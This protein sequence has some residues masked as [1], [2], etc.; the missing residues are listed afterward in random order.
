[1]DLLAAWLLFPL[2]LAVVAL[3]CGLLVDRLSDRALPGALLLPVGAATVLVLAR[4]LVAVPV[5]GAAGLA[6][7]LAVALGGLVVGLARLRELRPDPAAAAAALGVFAVFGAPVFLSGEP[8]LAGSFVLPDTSHQL[9]LAVHLGDTGTDW[10]SLPASSF[11]TGVGKYLVTAY[12]IGPQA[13]LGLLAPLGAIDLAWLYQPFLSFLAAITALSLY[14]LVA[15]WLASRALAAV[16]AFVGAQPA[17]VLGFALQGSIKEITG[18]AMIVLTSALVAVA[19]AER[20]PSQALLPAA[21]AAGAALGALGPVAVAYVGLPAAVLGLVWLERWLRRPR[22]RALA[23]AVA[24]VAVV[25]LLV[26]P[27]LSGASQAYSTGRAVLARGTAELGNL[28][29][30]L[31]AAQAVGPWL[32]GDYR[33]PVR[34]EALNGVLVAV[35]LVAALLGLALAL[36]RR[37]V[38]PLLLVVAV[39]PVSVY[40]LRRG[41]PYADAKVLV[42]AAPAVLTTAVFGAAA[43]TRGRWRALGWGLAA[44]VGAGV[45]VSNALAY[46]EVR[47]APYQR[48]RELARINE[49]F[50][51]QGPAVFT[52]YDEYAKY[53]LRDVR[54]ISQP[55]RFL[56]RFPY[57][58]S[59]KAM[60]D[61]DPNGPLLQRVPLVVMRRS[62]TVSRPPSNFRRVW[63][64]R[65]YEVWRRAPGGSARVLRHLALGQSVFQPSARPRCAQVASM[66]R[67]AARQGGRLAYVERPST[68]LY[69][70]LADSRTN[71]QFGFPLRVPYPVYPKAV[72]IA[73]AGRAAAKVR[74]PR[75]GRYRPYLEGSFGRGYEV[76]LDG[77]RVGKAAYDPSNPGGSVRLSEVTLSAGVHSLELVRG[78]GT[79]RPGNGGGYTSN[80]LY[81]GALVLSPPL[82]EAPPVRYVSPRRAAGLCRRTLD[83]VEVVVPAAS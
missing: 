44:V 6:V 60:I 70:P 21:L 35:A 64:G 62:P 80:L 58:P 69:D 57:H 25:A 39:V 8:S 27:V 7:L 15:R 18:I 54:P 55:E 9:A 82:N 41:T 3:G 12:P 11:R 17:L 10:R 47:A 29:G 72:V 65:S 74:V 71:D 16:V 19:V 20:R 63:S 43:L 13:A 22:S 61:L 48:Y 49:R 23:G 14:A 32:S 24:A 30:P 77:R 45:L 68:P 28:A 34:A 26:V 2:V 56:Q 76:F 78:G 53:F 33:Y 5:P 75:A 46:H 36:R 73:G 51:G 81:L 52:E 38:G 83:W 50:A 67:S 40:L 59:V 4:F 66:A 1:M 37:A 31:E 79:L 42:L